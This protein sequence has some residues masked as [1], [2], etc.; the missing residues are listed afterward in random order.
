MPEGHS[1]RKKSRS[2]TGLAMQKRALIPRQLYHQIQILSTISH[3]GFVK[4]HAT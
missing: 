1:T 4:N 2:S 3:K